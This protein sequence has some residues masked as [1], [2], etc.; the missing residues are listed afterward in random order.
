MLGIAEQ[1]RIADGDKYNFNETGLAMGLTSGPGAAK[2]VEASGNIWRAK[3]TGIT[4]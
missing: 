2:V 3:I 4:H 1:C